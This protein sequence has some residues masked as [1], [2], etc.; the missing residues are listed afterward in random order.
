MPFAMKQNK[1]LDPFPL[2]LL[3]PQRIMLEAHY[4]ANLIQQA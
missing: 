3:R 2:G 4:L 1:P